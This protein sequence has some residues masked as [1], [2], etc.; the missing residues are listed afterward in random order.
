MQILT[1]IVAVFLQL[2]T[3]ELHDV[4]SKHGGQ[5]LVIH[6]VLPHGP[7]D[8]PGLL[9][10]PLPAPVRV[11]AVQLGLH[12]VMFPGKGG[13]KR[14]EAHVLVN[15]P[16]TWWVAIIEVQFDCCFTQLYRQRN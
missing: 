5:P 15:T 10:Q 13:V 2:E 9:I 16:I 14:H 12:T 3:V 7:D 4:V 1:V 6:D 11:E 8:T